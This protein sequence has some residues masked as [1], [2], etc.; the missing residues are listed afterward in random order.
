MFQLGTSDVYYNGRLIHPVNSASKA[1]SRS[2]TWLMTEIKELQLD[3]K[4]EHL[5]AVR[6]ENHNQEDLTT[7]NFDAGFI[8]KLF[9]LGET[10][11]KLLSDAKRYTF[12]QTFFSMVPF[13]LFLLHFFLYVFYP[14]QSKIY[15]IP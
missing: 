14:G 3:N 11:N 13:I 6:Y 1:D 7:L 5:I 4:R 9:P 12:N 15:F 2:E 10:I 8:I